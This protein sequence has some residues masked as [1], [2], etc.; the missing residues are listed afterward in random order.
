MFLGLGIVAISALAMVLR[1]FRELQLTIVVPLVCMIAYKWLLA[2]SPVWFLSKGNTDN[3][4]KVVQKI[5]KM[6]EGLVPMRD[7][8][9]FQRQNDS[10]LSEVKARD[11]A[12]ADPSAIEAS[13]SFIDLPLLREKLLAGSFPCFILLHITK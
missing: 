10:E 2:E 6:S 11:P 13:L 12:N 3:A 1:D 5:A 9:E 8:Q 4:I 7:F